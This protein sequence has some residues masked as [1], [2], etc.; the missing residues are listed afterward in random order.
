MDFL[1][2]IVLPQSAEH[3]ELIR[4]L[5][6]VAFVILLPYLAFVTGS[7]FYSLLY[8]R[9]GKANDHLPSLL[10][11]KDLSELVTV[12]KIILFGI[13]LIP[14]ISIIF[15]YAQLLSG[16]GSLAAEYLIVALLVL[17]N[18][19]VAVAAYN[20][21]FNLIEEGKEISFGKNKLF[22]AIG[23]LGFVLLLIG[24]YI[25]VSSVQLAI[26]TEFWNMPNQI[27]AVT[28]ATP[29]IVN[30]LLFFIFALAVAPVVLLYVY[31]RPNT[32]KTGSSEHLEY[33]KAF[34]LKS[35]LIFSV[36]LPVYLL[37]A[38]V[39]LPSYALNNVSF[40][41]VL[42]ALILLIFAA[43]FVY[44]MRRD[45]SAQYAPHT[46]F[47]FILI[48]ALVVMKDHYAMGTTTKDHAAKLAA[49]YEEYQLELKKEMGI[50]VEEKVD[51]EAIFN[52]ICS[53][54]HSFD[55]RIVGPPYNE[56]LVKYEG[57]LDDLADFILNPR[58]INP[59]YPV[60]P[61]QGLKPNQAKAVAEFLMQHFE[62]NKK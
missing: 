18:A 2:N 16:S 60:M 13:I 10:L 39:S 36:V 53:A 28:V 62:E 19:L 56:T 7:V 37:L 25:I 11:A 46:I 59:D 9:K 33:I 12:S 3:I 52:T 21:A 57:K 15:G 31:F 23:W 29:T 58:K 34:A 50:A 45:K 41:A 22:I 27:S 48:F 4:G 38:V 35:A 44:V 30:F 14:L 32:S 5:V 61:N 42:V 40:F 26:E 55:K 17:I 47:F 24:T 1:Q 20:N 6:I 43:S 54:C 51:G 49:Q 8:A